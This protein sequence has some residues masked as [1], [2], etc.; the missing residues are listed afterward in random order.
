MKRFKNILFVIDYEL[1]DCEAFNRAVALA[2]NNQANLTVVS[3]LDEF[4]KDKKHKIY[5]V[6]ITELQDVMLEKRRLQLERQV[7][8]IRKKIRV[9]TKV[10][11]GTPFMALIWEVLRFKRDILIKVAEKEDGVIERFFASTDMRLLRKCPC[12]VWLMKSRQAEIPRKILAA[13]DFDPCDK[14][15]ADNEINRQIIE[16]STSLALSEFIELHIVHVWNAY[17]ETNLRSGFAEQAEADVDS[18]VEGIRLEHKNQL[19]E[20]LANFSDISGTPS[21]YQFA[22]F[23]DA[24]TIAGCSEV[25]L[26]SGDFKYAANV[27]APYIIVHNTG[28]VGGAGF[29]FIDSNSGADWKFKSTT[30]ASFKIRDQANGV[31]VLEFY[32]SSAAHSLVIEPEKTTIETDTIY[33]IGDVTVTGNII[34]TGNVSIIGDLQYSDMAYAV[35]ADGYVTNTTTLQTTSKA[36]DIKDNYNLSTTQNI[37]VL[38]DSAIQVDV[39]GVYKITY[40]MMIKVS[41]VGMVVFIVKHNDTG[42]SYGCGYRRWSF[43]ANTS[44]MIEISGIKA[45]CSANDYFELYAS[46]PSGS[47]TLTVE[48][49]QVIIEKISGDF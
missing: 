26:T 6:S 21:Q 44:T 9:N 8:P 13:V 23:T 30:Y 42:G 45:G 12:P 2:E 40:Q 29:E 25:T 15:M 4:P 36:L 49:T 3:I 7:A 14:N 38:S 19:D 20:L 47:A 11:I 31:D 22:W 48:S 28:N 39:P 33:A 27:T 1:Q 34:D 32:P 41:A 24:N 17:G 5:G 46:R 35:L 10:L 37:T 16:M 43:A 18:Y